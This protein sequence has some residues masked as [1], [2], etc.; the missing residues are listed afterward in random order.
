MKK[1]PNIVLT[2]VA[3]A[4]I[5]DASGPPIHIFM[6]ASQ[7]PTSSARSLCSGLGS[8]GACPDAP[9]FI[10][11]KITLAAKHDKGIRLR[12]EFL[13]GN[14]CKLIELPCTGLILTR[15]QQGTLRAVFF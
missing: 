12:I 14:W 5:G 13:Q 4:S 1:G 9:A 7:V 11:K 3:V 6:V 10:D 2:S 15:S 8:G